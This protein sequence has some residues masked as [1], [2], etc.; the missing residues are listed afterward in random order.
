[1]EHQHA[2]RNSFFQ[3]RLAVLRVDRE[4]AVIGLVG[5][6]RI[7]VTRCLRPRE[8]VYRRCRGFA[9]ISD[10][11]LDADHA[12]II[13]AFLTVYNKLEFCADRITHALNK[14]D[15][16]RNDRIIRPG[17]SQAVEIVRL[18]SIDIVL[19]LQAGYGRAI[20][21]TGEPRAC[22]HRQGRRPDPRNIV[23]IRDIRPSADG[24]LAVHFGRCAI[25]ID[26]CRDIKFCGIVDIGRHGYR[27]II[28]AD[29]GAYCRSNRALRFN[30]AIIH[31]VE[32]ACLEIDK[33]IAQALHFIRPV[34]IP[35]ILHTFF[36][37]ILRR[38]R[39]YAIAHPV[40]YQR[41]R[42]IAPVR[43]IRGCPDFGDK[44]DICARQLLILK[45]PGATTKCH[46][47]RPFT[48]L[49]LPLPSCRAVS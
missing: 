5:A 34:R 39:E 37:E 23:I 47:Y 1:M 36:L 32:I 21:A 6:G 42:A 41:H 14:C 49:L 15:K 28:A 45:Q 25:N 17:V 26:V 29:A 12:L 9:G 38:Y 43:D 7:D 2:R 10:G 31:G 22:R 11:I 30:R 27:D 33:Q 20:R 16:Q 13:S 3:V 40:K 46:S 48:Y 8:P 35:E 19:I 24:L 44:I 18:D 4:L